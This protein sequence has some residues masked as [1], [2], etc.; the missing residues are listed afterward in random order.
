VTRPT[1]SLPKGI[2]LW[3]HIPAGD[4]VAAGWGPD[5]DLALVITDS[6]DATV[7]RGG[8]SGSGAD[9]GFRA[10]LVRVPPDGRGAR[11]VRVE[12]ELVASRVQPLADGGFLV[13]SSRCA[14][15]T[16]GTHELNGA[17]LAAD[18]HEVRRVLLGDGIGE[19]Q[20]D[21]DGCIWV[22]YLDEGVF[23]NLGWDKPVGAP[24]LIRFAP[25]GDVLWKYPQGFEHPPEGDVMRGPSG[26]N[27]LP[28]I[29]DCYAMNVAYD[30]VWICPYSDFP[31]VR[32]GLDGATRSWPPFGVDGPAAFAVDH[33]RVLMFGGYRSNGDL[34]RVVVADVEDDVVR[35]G[36]EFD[37]VG[38]DGTPLDA[39][40]RVEGRG[41]TL[42]V[43]AG[44]TWSRLDVRDFD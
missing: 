32:I 18:G 35:P 28:P 26:A 27:A 11:A 19:L 40:I 38:P 41:P 8:S 5:D 4:V 23:G 22:G 21:R 31:L 37:L 20:L 33:G 12:L 24:G 30:A 10:T 2:D 42:H 39:N 14:R 25:T 44:T 34:R 43:L 9:R 16:D 36:R 13:A 1:L 7:A 3:D 15:Y 17:I 29:D 6:T